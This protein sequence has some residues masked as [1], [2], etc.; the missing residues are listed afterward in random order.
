MRGYALGAESVR[1]PNSVGLVIGA[2]HPGEAKV[3]LDYL[4]SEPVRISLAAAKALES[5]ELTASFA[6]DWPGVLASAETDLNFL[7]GVILR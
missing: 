4:L 2:P 7:K 5:T 3:F 1:T 6:I